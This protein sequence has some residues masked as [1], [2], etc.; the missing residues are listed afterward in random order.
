M[1]LTKQAESK[2]ASAGHVEASLVRS[3]RLGETTESVFRTTT[4][5]AKYDW[6]S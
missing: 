4:V 6:L 1:C 3:G 2:D 5:A